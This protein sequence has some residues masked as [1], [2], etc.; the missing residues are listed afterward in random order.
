MQKRNVAISV[1]VVVIMAV[2]FYFVG[3]L[4]EIVPKINGLGGF[5]EPRSAGSGFLVT[6]LSVKPG[7]VKPNETVI[8]TVSVTNTYKILSVYI[9]VLNING[10]KEAEKQ[11]NLDAGSSD[12]VSFSLTRQDPGSYTAFI[13]GLSGTFTVVPAQ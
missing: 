8:I 4:R 6:G 12:N 13:N 5:V 2:G 11:V 10:A 9:L 1:L 7:R 3:P